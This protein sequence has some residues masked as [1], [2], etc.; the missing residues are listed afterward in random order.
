MTNIIIIIII[1]IIIMTEYSDDYLL[2]WF[3][4]ITA[5]IIVIWYNDHYY[6]DLVRWNYHHYDLTKLPLNFFND[7][8]SHPYL[9]TEFPQLK[10]QF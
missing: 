1:I 7:L 4:T 2:L 10:K 9:L 3:N 6:H 8:I 5:I